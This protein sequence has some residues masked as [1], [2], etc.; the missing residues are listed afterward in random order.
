MK[1]NKEK[2]KKVRECIT[3]FYKTVSDSK[4]AQKF[5]MNVHTVSV[6]RRRLGLKKDIDI[7]NGLTVRFDNKRKSRIGVDNKRISY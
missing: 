4:I 1:R 3:Q 7:V 6:I 5:D 2:A